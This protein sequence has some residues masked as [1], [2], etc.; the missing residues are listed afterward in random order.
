MKSE[1][2][3]GSDWRAAEVRAVPG[4]LGGVLGESLGCRIRQKRVQILGLSLHDSITQDK[5]FDRCE[6]AFFHE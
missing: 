5:S 1:H 3:A 6:P 4:C 2:E